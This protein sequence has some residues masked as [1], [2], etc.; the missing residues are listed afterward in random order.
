MSQ[1]FALGGQS[2]GVPASA[3][4]LPM[5]TQ[6]FILKTS[7]KG[8]SLGSAI[9]LAGRQLIPWLTTVLPFGVP[10]LERRSF[11]FRGHWAD[12]GFW[13]KDAALGGTVCEWSQKEQHLARAWSLV[14]LGNLGVYSC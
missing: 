11:I 3:S 13:G 8:F 2:I 5:N 9:N 14:S 12:F 6:D 7:P 10:N 4:V 1:L